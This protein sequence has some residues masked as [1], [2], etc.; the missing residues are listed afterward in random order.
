MKKK[1]PIYK[2]INATEIY[3]KIEYDKNGDYIE[4]MEQ[5]ISRLWITFCVVSMIIIVVIIFMFIYFFNQV[6]FGC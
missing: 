1:K 4:Q 2:K 5:D 3:E 6:S